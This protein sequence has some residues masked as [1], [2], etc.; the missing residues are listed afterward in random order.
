MRHQLYWSSPSGEFGSRFFTQYTGGPPSV[1]DCTAIDTLV[2]AAYVA[3]LAALCSDTIALVRTVTTDLTTPTGA[4]GENQPLCAG[5]AGSG[6]VPDSA[7]VD[8]LFQTAR[9]YRGGKARIYLPPAGGADMLDDQHWTPAFV[10]TAGAA[11]AAFMTDV[12]AATSGTTLQTN[13]VALGYY[14]GVNVPT[15]LPSGRVKQTS[16]LRAVPLEDIVT[17]H[18]VRAIIGSQR[19]RLASAT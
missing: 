14:S 9:R 10:G 4:Q 6:D 11:W 18:T 7:C 2:V 17:G 15:T 1:A 13:Q 8:I 19:K 16:K 3:H 5:T 12:L